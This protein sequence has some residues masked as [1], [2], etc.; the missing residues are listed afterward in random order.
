[1]L[2]QPEQRSGFFSTTKEIVVL[3]LIV[4]LIRTFLFGLYQVPSGSMETTMLIGERFFADKLSYVFRTP[5]RH[6]IISFNT[7]L[8]NYST[9]FFM[10]MFQDYVWGPDN[11][12]KRVIGLPGDT[13]RGTVEEGKPVLYVNGQKVDEP[14]VNKYPLIGLWHINPQQLFEEFNRKNMSAFNNDARYQAYIE[15]VVYKNSSFRSYDP[16]QPYGAA[17]PFYNIN[18]E[19]IIRDEAGNPQIRQAGNP[20]AGTVVTTDQAGQQEHWNGTD[21]YYVVL[22]ENQYWVMGDNRLG[23]QDSRFFGPLDG[24]LI[25]GRIVF[26]IFSIDSTQSW[27]FVDLLFNPIG[28]FKRVRW[29]RCFEFIS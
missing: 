9:N 24:R 19:L 26:R 20:I 6:E 23:S 7:P 12:T 5:K 8:F 4:F 1:M 22:K 25:H 28:F 3:L 16:A 17:Q 18:P 29:S 2:Q 27:W 21:D 14:F 13:I 15:Q 11:W 10:R